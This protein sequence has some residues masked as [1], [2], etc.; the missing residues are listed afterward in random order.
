MA[1]QFPPVG[2]TAKLPRLLGIA[3]C[4]LTA[5]SCLQAGEPRIR[6][7]SLHTVLTE[8]ASEVGGDQVEVDALVRPGD[9]PHTYQPSP[10]AVA[11][12]TRADIVLAA[13][14]NLEPYLDRL[15][16]NAG[17]GGR[18]VAVGDSVP[19]VLSVPGGTGLF[20]RE[21]ERDPHWWHS[22]EDML[23]ATELVRREFTLMRPEDAAAFASRA[24]AYEGRLMVLR[25][26]AEAEISRLPPA[27]RQLV[28]S[29]DAFG[30]LAR[31]YG[32]TIHSINGLSPDGEPDARDL[33]LLIDLVRSEHIR[34]IF[35]ES[36]TNPR[37][38]RGLLE[39]TGARLGGVLYADGLGPAGSGAATYGAMFRH[40][41]TA[42][43]SGLAPEPRPT[44]QSI[45]P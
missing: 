39:E 24:R 17:V 40:N 29:H 33:S 42:I 15:V 38:V 14:L 44:A 12:M 13:G 8:I 41:V 30:Y 10:E 28:T 5:A 4:A 23:F 45:P 21:G 9:D 27:S 35:P 11:R 32:F 7:A 36:T 34:A 37:V 31:D 26:W 25:A 1:S 22:I 43:V 2:T 16:R 19:I 3:L 6:V 18:V 20:S